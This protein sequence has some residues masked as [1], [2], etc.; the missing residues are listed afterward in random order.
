L[1][2]PPHSA[3]ADLMAR[4]SASGIC[5]DLASA[6][7]HPLRPRRRCFRG[8]DDSG[9]GPREIIADKAMDSIT[10]PRG[11]DASRGAGLGM[12][13]PTI[14]LAGRAAVLFNYVLRPARFIG[15]CNVCSSL[16]VAGEFRTSKKQLP[17]L[18]SRPPSPIKS[19]GSAHLLN[20]TSHMPCSEL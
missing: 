1:A 18:R 12:V 7:G 9:R 3:I 5:A 15:H 20:C 2:R 6:S 10:G 16:N 19:K 14:S 8:A 17:T 13:Q 11:D 4:W